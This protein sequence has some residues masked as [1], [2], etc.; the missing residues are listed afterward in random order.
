MESANNIFVINLLKDKERLECVSQELN[1]HSIKFQRFDAVYG[2]DLSDDEINK[3]VSFIGRNLL[4]HHSMVGCYLSHVNLWKKLVEDKNN[5]FYLIFEDDIT[6]KDY[7]SLSKLYNLYKN[8]IINKDFLSLFVMHT[9][10]KISEIVDYDGVPICKKLFP[11]SLAGYFI[12]KKGANN[13]LKRLGNQIH[14]HIDWTLVYLSKVYKD[15][16]IYNTYNNL[17]S[18]N[19][20]GLLK[21]NNTGNLQQ[22]TILSLMPPDKYF[23]FQ[24]PALII[25]MKYN[26][27]TECILSLIFSIF[28]YY[29]SIKRRNII[30]YILFIITFTNFILSLF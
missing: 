14:Y 23:S 5:D 17:L 22:K 12:T 7:E 16:E 15:C 13:I 25:K 28:F 11:F 29:V 30:F 10:I 9:D 21:S 8:N 4:C 2:K 1:K 3:K 26:I 27:S 20:E 18:L 19:S 24:S 6:I